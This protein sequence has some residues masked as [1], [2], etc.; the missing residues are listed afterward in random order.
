M[1]HRVE[2]VLLRLWDRPHRLRQEYLADL[3]RLVGQEVHCYQEGQR[4]PRDQSHRKGRML[5]LHHRGL[6]GQEQE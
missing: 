2:Q 6:E 1:S 5:R 3:E 4:D